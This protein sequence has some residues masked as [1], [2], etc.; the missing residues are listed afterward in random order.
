MGIF[1]RM[2]ERLVYKV[3]VLAFR[4]KDDQCIE[5]CRFVYGM[6]RHWFDKDDLERV[7]K[8][9]AVSVKLPEGTRNSQECYIPIVTRA[10][11]RSDEY[12]YIWSPAGAGAANKI[13][14][15]LGRFLQSRGDYIFDGLVEDEEVIKDFMELFNKLYLIFFPAPKTGTPS[16]ECSE[17][18]AEKTNMLV[19]SI[20]DHGKKPSY[21]KDK[22]END[23]KII[24]E[25]ESFAASVAT[26]D[27]VVLRNGAE[28]AYM[29]MHGGKKPQE[30]YLVKFCF[31]AIPGLDRAVLEEV[32]ALVDEHYSQKREADEEKRRRN[33]AEEKVKQEIADEEERTRQ[34]EEKAKKAKEKAEEKAQQKQYEDEA[35]AR[36]KAKSDDQ[37]KNQGGTGQNPQ[38]SKSGQKPKN[39][40][41]YTGQQI[42]N[43]LLCKGVKIQDIPVDFKQNQSATFSPQQIKAIME[44]N[45]TSNLG[46]PV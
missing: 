2:G 13:K 25:V 21:L 42:I 45:N 43:S 18:V 46:Y 41:E 5:I 3:D 22:K 12:V 33:E 20:D 15:H 28:H 9:R 16:A 27:M 1:S 36:L 31:R 32:D 40:P 11:K 6:L 34:K 26:T 10:G 14:P 4:K 38:G 39:P 7:M 17:R 29:T 30:E 24:K 37:S 44:K 35:R 19:H 8:K 23:R